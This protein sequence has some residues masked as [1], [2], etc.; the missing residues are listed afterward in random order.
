M[1]K[2]FNTP[3]F[4]ARYL[5]KENNYSITNRDIGLFINED[6][7][8]TMSNKTGNGIN[9]S[10]ERKSILLEFEPQVWIDIISELITLALEPSHS[11]CEYYWLDNLN[12]TVILETHNG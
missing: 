5:I 10:E 4:R 6:I 1:P 12:M 2:G 11:Y 7:F 8:I 9:I 3:P